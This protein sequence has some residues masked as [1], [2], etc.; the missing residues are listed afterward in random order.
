MCTPTLLPVVFDVLTKPWMLRV[1]VCAVL[2]IPPG[3]VGHLETSWLA[4]TI[5]SSPK[6]SMFQR[7]LGKQ[8]RIL[9]FMSAMFLYIDLCS[10]VLLWT[11]SQGIRC[12]RSRC[13]STGIP[14]EAAMRSLS[15]GSLGFGG[16]FVGSV[17]A[18]ARASEEDMNALDA[19]YQTKINMKPGQI[20]AYVG[21][22]RKF[23][24]FDLQLCHW[25][26]SRY[27]LEAHF[28][29]SWLATLPLHVH[30][31]VVKIP[32]RQSWVFLV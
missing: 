23:W 3:R 15:F 21:L 30:Q 24:T 16:W 32:I 2:I 7:L 8:R 4:A 26:S 11:K 19:R 9:R 17:V 27:D 10:I 13:I 29:P 20:M 22:A 12:S 6:A 18:D 31:N 25:H 28:G 5:S 14:W 1:V